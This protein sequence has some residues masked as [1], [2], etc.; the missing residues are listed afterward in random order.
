[1]TSDSS[2]KWVENLAEQER[3]IFQGEKSSVDLTKTK[4]EVLAVST[5][6]FFR[7]LFNQFEY[8]SRL[9]NSH[10][11]DRGPGI[12]LDRENELFESFALLRNATRLFISGHR[13]GFVHVQCEKKLEGAG[14]MRSS[15]MFSGILEAKFATFDEVQWFFLGSPVTAEQV[16]R[17]YLTEFLQTSRD[18]QGLA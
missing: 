14:E 12:R 9:F 2:I 8:L 18:I 7:Q 6:S 16:A 17:H 1:M 3:L 5:A 4:E 15:V 11:A 13:P 10:L